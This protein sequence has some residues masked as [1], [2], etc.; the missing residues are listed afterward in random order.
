[1][2]KKN[3]KDE[4][5]IDVVVN[6]IYLRERKIMRRENSYIVDDTQEVII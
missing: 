2:V 1:M 4:E 3:I 6:I 5:Y